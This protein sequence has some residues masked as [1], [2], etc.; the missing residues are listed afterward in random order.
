MIQE[1]KDVCAAGNKSATRPEG[2]KSTLQRKL[3]T[4]S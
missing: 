1:V 4:K 2:R 3:V